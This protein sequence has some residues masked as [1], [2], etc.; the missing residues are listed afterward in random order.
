MGGIYAK[1][2]FSLVRKGHKFGRENG[3]NAYGRAWRR[4]LANGNSRALKE[5]Q[6]QTK[7]PAR[8]LN[9]QPQETE[10]GRSV[11]LRNSRAAWAA[12]GDCIVKERMNP[13]AG[14]SA[15][16]ECLLSLQETLGLSKGYCVS[17]SPM[18]FLK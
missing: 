5:R 10:V 6:K 12:W 16:A 4:Y 1:E 14:C 15:V 7:N 8:C 18:S 17:W 9:S 3:E 2:Q 11:K 13:L